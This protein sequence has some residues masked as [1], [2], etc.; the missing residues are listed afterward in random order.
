LMLT[1][2]RIAEIGSLR[3][4]EI[5]GDRILLP[6]S[7]TKNGRAHV[8]PLS[9]VARAILDDRPRR[10]GRDFIFG[11]EQDRPFTGWSV[12]KATLDARIGA[13]VPHWTHHDLR[14]TAATRMA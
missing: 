11:R 13:A 1:G 4:S 2:Q 6:A 14:R 12:S 7:R 5:E 8:V 10:D 9:A 3:W